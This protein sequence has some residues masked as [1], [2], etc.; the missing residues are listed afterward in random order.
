MPR[1]RDESSDNSPTEGHEIVHGVSGHTNLQHTQHVA[2]IPEIETG[3][4]LPGMGAGGVADV[5]QG[6]SKEFSTNFPEKQNLDDVEKNEKNSKSTNSDS[7]VSGDSSSRPSAPKRQKTDNTDVSGLQNGVSAS[8]LPS[9]PDSTT[10]QHKPTD[11]ATAKHSSSELDQLTRHKAEKYVNLAEDGIDLSSTSTKQDK[12]GS[13]TAQH[14]ESSGESG[15]ASSKEKDEHDKNADTESSYKHVGNGKSAA[16]DQKKTNESAAGFGHKK[17]DS[18]QSQRVDGG[19]HRGHDLEKVQR[20]Q[21]EK[22]GAV[23]LESE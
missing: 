2:P 4:A 9:D 10:I 1:T 6:N 12:T 21:A 5:T 18:A 13:R 8:S 14:P 11:E 20:H 19:F 3:D 22:F 15:S 23:N 16:G 17:S 7:N